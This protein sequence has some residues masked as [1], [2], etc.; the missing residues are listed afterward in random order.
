MSIALK[1]RRVTRIAAVV[2]LALLLL[3]S[4]LPF[5]TNGL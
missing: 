3:A 5:I 2:A 4:A 1:T